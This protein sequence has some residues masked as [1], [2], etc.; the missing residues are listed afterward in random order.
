MIAERN[1]RANKAVAWVAGATIALGAALVASA[2]EDR[3]VLD[4]ITSVFTGDY[5]VKVIEGNVVN[6]GDHIVLKDAQHRM[7]TDP[8]VFTD[9]PR[10]LRTENGDLYLILTGHFEDVQLE[11]WDRLHRGE[12]AVHGF[13]QDADRRLTSP[14][15]TGAMEHDPTTAPADR[16]H[17]TTA[18]RSQPADARGPSVYDRDRS[19]ERAADRRAENAE[20]MAKREQKLREAVS[21]ARAKLD[22][23][24]ETP[25]QSFDEAPMGGRVAVIGRIYSNNGLQAILV[26][27][28]H[29]DRDDSG[30]QAR[31]D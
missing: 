25:A 11:R 15:R 27:S 14:E 8:G 26:E 16:P 18:D 2:Q 28:I 22:A 13:G 7:G 21:D 31:A 20:D 6:L 17:P 4:R 9:G 12:A 19:T 23:A 3:G 10:G 1:G 30:P 24:Y 29:L 5:N